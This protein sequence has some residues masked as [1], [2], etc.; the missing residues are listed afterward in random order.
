MNEKLSLLGGDPVRKQPFAPW[1]VFDDRERTALE[2]VL[3]SGNWGGSPSPNRKAAE[4]AA[5]F[6]AIH[7]TLFAIP[8]SSGTAA[9]EVALKALGV[10]PGDEVIVPALTYHATAYAVVACMARPVFADVCLDTACIDPDSAARLITSRTRAII[11]VHYGAA[12]ADLD[13][14]AEL[15][16]SRSLAIVEDCCEAVGAQWRGRGV[17]SYGAL[18]CFSFQSLKSLTAGEG[19]MITTSDHV[20]AQ[21]CQALI[22]GRRRLGDDCAE[23]LLGANYRI[24]EWQCAVLLAQLERLPAQNEL[25][26]KHAERL[27]AALERIPGLTPTAADPRTTRPATYVW[28][29]KVNASVLNVSRNLFALALMAEGIPCSIG[30]EPVFRSPLFPLESREYRTVCELAGA[31]PDRS[32]CRCPVAERLYD[33]ELLGLP[34]QCLLGEEQDLDDVITAIEKVAANAR[35]LQ[36]AKLGLLWRALERF[37]HEHEFLLPLEI[38]LERARCYRRCIDGHRAECRVHLLMK[39]AVDAMVR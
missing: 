21:R 16:R 30:D 3:C 5:R 2:D 24:T 13:A 18:G 9:L 26:W 38:V 19:G 34:H 1:P 29:F 8:T 33:H 23:S 20:L 10:G 28:F 4:L 35:T 37:W 12:I 14:L 17:G 31:A 7:D 22:N 25:R 32:A 39:K 36:R 6:A 11:P 15:A 27:R